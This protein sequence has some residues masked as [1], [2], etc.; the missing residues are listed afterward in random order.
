[1]LIRGWVAPVLAW[2][3]GLGGGKWPTPAKNPPVSGAIVVDE[4]VNTSADTSLESVR[5]PTWLSMAA[6]GI[7]E[8]GSARM[9]E[10]T[11]IITVIQQI[12]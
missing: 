1:M 3:A 9:S 11:D 7:L 5:V 10:M 12:L 8:I 4:L 2:V 6:T